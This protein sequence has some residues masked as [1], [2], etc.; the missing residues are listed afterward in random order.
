MWN[1][2]QGYLADRAEFWGVGGG[3]G[4]RH[5]FWLPKHPICY[6][7]GVGDGEISPRQDLLS[8]FSLTGFFYLEI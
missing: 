4:K 2:D 1:S 5:R 6:T 7:K 8:L 3:W